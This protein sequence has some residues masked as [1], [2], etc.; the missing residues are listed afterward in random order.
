MVVSGETSVWS[1][2]S[3]EVPQGSILG[4]LLFIVY[5][6]Y[7]DEKMTSTVLKFAD[8]TKIS[9]NSQQELQR[10]L[11]TALEWAQTWQM[12]FNTSKC[13]KVMHVG[14]RNER[15]IYNMGNHRLEEVEEEKDL[16]VLIHRTLSVSNN[17]AVAV[18][19]ANQ[20]AGHIYRTVTHKSIQTAVPLYKA[21]VRPYLEYCSLVWSPYLKK[22]ILSIEKVQ[23]RVTQK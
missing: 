6:N 17:C 22:D 11:D 20:M 10:D 15:A 14:H 1:A 12:H 7:L 8:D 23:R 2:V 5:I 18:K 16:G 13:S 19:K 9:S 21:V 3:S 4:P